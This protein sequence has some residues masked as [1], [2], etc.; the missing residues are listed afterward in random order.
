MTRLPEPSFIE[1]DPEK[2]TA[3]MVSQYEDMTGKTLYPAQV[4]RLMVDF[5]GYRESLVRMGAQDA[6]IQNISRFARAPI[7]DFLAELLAVFRLQAQPARSTLRIVFESPV[8]DA[9]QVASGVRVETRKGGVR[10][11]TERAV[12]V[13]SGATEIVL[14]VVAVEP[15]PSGN[16]YLPGQLDTLV[17]SLPVPIASVANTTATSGGMNP[18]EDD[19]LRAR[20]PRELEMYSWGGEG[21][22]RQIAM[23]TAS[24]LQDVG[25]TSP[26]PDG[27]VRVVLLA[28]DGPPSQETLDRVLVAL[29]DKKKRMMG[30]R[31]EVVPAS[32]VK[33]AIAVELDVLT[34]YIPDPILTAA[35]GRCRAFA[36]NLARRLGGDIVPNMIKT[37][38]H[39]IP[40]IYD[41][42]ITEPASR[43]VLGSNEWPICIGVTITLGR[44]VDDV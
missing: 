10:F 9:F 39:D 3:E 12:E 6:A 28:R 19:R 2:L 27:T 29:T 36:D 5:V 38:L 16:G 22:Y 4:D 32:A 42:R 26:R 44:V 15:G 24:E 8:V 34:G 25:V 40:G 1:R 11:K 37:H 17:D 43:R 30:D 18:E 14:P 7:L 21:R 35:R 13:A 41:I 20:I 33:Y 23:T 31:I